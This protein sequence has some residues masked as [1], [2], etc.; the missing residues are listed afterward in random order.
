MFI[1][2]QCA[3]EVCLMSKGFEQGGIHSYVLQEYY[4]SVIAE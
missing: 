2:K 1:E 3:R 4:L